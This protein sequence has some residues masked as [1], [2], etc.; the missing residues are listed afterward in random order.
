MACLKW[1][2]SGYSCLV[3]GLQIRETTD[4]LRAECPRWRECGST[5]HIITRERAWFMVP[6]AEAR[7]AGRPRRG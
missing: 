1:Q 5:S 2:D 7:K 4:G 3:H 6:A